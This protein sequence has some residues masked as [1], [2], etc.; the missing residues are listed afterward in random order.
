MLRHRVGLRSEIREDP[1]GAVIAEDG[2]VIPFADAYAD[3][4]AT[5]HGDL[6]GVLLPGQLLPDA[7]AFLAQSDPIGVLVCEVQH[8][9]WQRV[10]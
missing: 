7:A 10:A 9:A 1:L 6:F 5:G 2:N 3:E 8:P 4:R